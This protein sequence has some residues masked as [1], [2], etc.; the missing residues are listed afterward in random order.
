MS[1]YHEINYIMRIEDH[2]ER[3]RL[4][5]NWL[6]N[7]WLTAALSRTVS[8]SEVAHRER[9]GSTE[10][11]K[12]M[13]ELVLKK[14]FLKDCIE[15]TLVTEWVPLPPDSNQECVVRLDFIRPRMNQ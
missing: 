10:E 12:K 15:P 7:N 6:K 5:L 1:A 3:Q 8:R 11:M 2:A 13:D 4:F 14:A 9:A